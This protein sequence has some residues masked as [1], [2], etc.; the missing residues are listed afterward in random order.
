MTAGFPL[1]RV[2]PPKAHPG[3]KTSEAMGYRDPTRTAILG[4]VQ[5]ISVDHKLSIE[6]EPEGRRSLTAPGSDI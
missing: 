5:R 4:D 6:T 2:F 3:T 1:S